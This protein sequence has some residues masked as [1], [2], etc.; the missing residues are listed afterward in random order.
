MKT[1]RQIA[2]FSTW[3]MS[4]RDE[5]TRAKIV[6]RIER[7]KSGLGK[8]KAVG[9]GVIELVIDFGPGWRIYFIEVE[10]QIIL[11]LG[12]GDKSTQ[13][14]DIAAARETVRAMKQAA[15]KAHSQ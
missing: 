2:K 1:V 6:Q 5:T 15:T 9:G 7:L 13:Q 12:G 8:T 4:L 3:L 11:L 10:G 14:A